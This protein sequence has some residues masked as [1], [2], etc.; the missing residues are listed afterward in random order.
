MTQIDNLL[1]NNRLQVF[2]GKNSV[3]AILIFIILLLAFPYA[4]SLFEK[5]EANNIPVLSLDKYEIG[6]L[7]E[8]NDFML[9]D[10]NTKSIAYFLKDSLCKII[11][12][13]IMKIEHNEYLE[14]TK[15]KK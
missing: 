14:T 6:Y 4:A 8:S 12:F 15:E 10:R 13:Q 9:Y 3:I 5:P 11:H 7:I 2:K 1:T